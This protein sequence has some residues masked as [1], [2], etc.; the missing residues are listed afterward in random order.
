MLTGLRSQLHPGRIQG[1]VLLPQPVFYGNQELALQDAVEP[2]ICQAVEAE[3][4]GASMHHGR[5]GSALVAVLLCMSYDS[6]RVLK[7]Y[8]DLEVGPGSQEQG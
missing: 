2:R 7:Y 3:E 6:V 8:L 1:D 5:A 4:A